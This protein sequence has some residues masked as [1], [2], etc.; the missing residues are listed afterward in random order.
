MSRLSLAVL[1]SSLSALSFAAPV[2]IPRLNAEPLPLSAPAASAGTAAGASFAG[3]AL[4][5]PKISAAPSPLAPAPAVA[6]PAAVPAPIAPAV[7]AAAPSAA[8]PAASAAGASAGVSERGPPVSPRS[9]AGVSANVARTVASWGAPVEDILKTHD[10]LLVGENHGSL[11][12]V[13]TLAHEMPRLAKAGVKAVGI[14]GLKRPHQAEVD[15]YVSG[16]TDRIPDDALAFS[17]RRRAAFRV[18]LRAARENGVRVVALGMPLDQWAQQAAS[19]AAQKTGDPVETFGASAAGQFQRAQ[20]GYEPGFNE[21]VAEVYLTRRN[22]M[23][24]AFLAD[25]MKAGGKAVVLV[26][27]AHVEGLDMVPGRLLHAPG[28]WGTL[29]RE[30]GGLALRAFSLTSTGGIFVDADAAEMDR[31]ARPE[32]YRL[33]AEHSP[34]GRPKYT[35]LGPDRGLWHAGGRVPAA[36]TAR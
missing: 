7:L 9:L 27:Q 15:A 25:S 12:S 19:L 23:M 2:E 29:A 1:L 33:A 35:P 18:L 13:S 26:G 3:P 6:L 21:A 14:E 4:S 16:E 20:N 36:Q 32:S 5:A 11:E 31:E 22:R 8:V 24:A 34:E 17:P 30:L 10:V 28:D